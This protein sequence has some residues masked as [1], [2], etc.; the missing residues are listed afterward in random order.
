MV[1]FSKNLTMT[2]PLDSV[3][4]QQKWPPPP[5]HFGN[6]NKKMADPLQT[7][8]ITGC[9]VKNNKID[10]E[11]VADPHPATFSEWCTPARAAELTGDS[12]TTIKRHCRRGKFK[13]ATKA[14]VNGVDA[15]QIPILSLP[16]AAQQTLAAEVKVAMLA[17]ANAIAPANPDQAS[18]TMSAADYQAA[19]ESYEESKPEHKRRAEL[20]FNALAAF[21]DLVDDGYSVGAAEMATIS[22]H[23]VSKPTLWRYRN[24]IKG[25]AR[26]NWLP[27][28][29]PRYTGGRPPAEFTQ[30]AY[31]YIRGKHKNQSETPLA[32]VVEN[33]R[34]L[35]PVKGW[36]IPSYDAI[37]DRLAKEPKWLDIIGRKGPDAL[38]RS[39][40]ALKKSY[41]SLALHEMWESDGRRAD[42]FCVWPDGTI[43]RPFII[44][45][46]E[47]RSRLVLSA[48]GYI[49]PTAAHVI[50]AFGMAMER[51]VTAPDFGKIDNGREYAAKPVTG[52]QTNRYRFTLVPGEQPGVMTLAGTKAFWSKPRRGQ[53]KPVESF[54]NYIA[55]RCDK[56]PEFE[57]AYCGRN[58][59]A[60]PEGFDRRNAIPIAAYAEK[61]AATLEYFNT[62]HRHTGDG[63][64]G[65]T[66]MEVYTELNAVT[67]RDPVDPALIRM[68]KMGRADIKPDKEDSTYTLVIPGY[69]KC[70]YHSPEIAGLPAAVLSRKHAVYYDLENPRTPVDI[71]DGG[72]KIGEAE[73]FGEID[74]ND[75][76]GHKAADH[77]KAKNAYMKPK[78]AALKTIKAAAQLEFPGLPAVT[79]LT[80]LPPPIHSVTIEGRRRPLIQSE[81]EDRSALESTDTP[82][83]FIDKETGELICRRV[84]HLTPVEA[85]NKEEAE[86]QRMRERRRQRVQ[87]DWMRANAPSPQ[88]QTHL[89]N[90][91][92]T[93]KKLKFAP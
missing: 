51:T 65:H 70:R 75:Q 34:V 45:W 52:G 22:K 35:A 4:R 91:H 60:K 46:R 28:L 39:Y 11:K 5:G 53:D 23:G 36:A 17:Q 71:W 82:G 9:F 27:L 83:E 13:G 66:P 18:M 92:D 50:S 29:V 86:L 14:T 55:D 81:P 68:C 85:D 32:V 80:P 19:W 77:V 1:K 87:P 72:R 40:P 38:E 43:A 26:C 25:H 63:M 7:R 21:H 79:G 56:A 47:V 10:G 84:H 41:R 3:K 2:R 61:L 89:E 15:W 62:Q 93:G 88:N 8:T 76:G 33:A 49:N 16:L 12:L 67:Q 78:K 20:A 69:G 54:W 58:P 90:E 6:D 59:V 44:V 48:K 57:G 64:G 42:V 31:E 73:L 30:E 37:A 24:L 74:F